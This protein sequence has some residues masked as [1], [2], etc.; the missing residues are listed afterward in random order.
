MQTKEIKKIMRQLRTYKLRVQDVPE[1][2][3]DNMDI[4][5]AERRYGLRKSGNRG[6]DAINQE[7]FVEEEIFYKNFTGDMSGFS[8]KKVFDEFEAYYNFLKGDIYVNSCYCYYD[9]SKDEEFIKKNKIDVEKLQERKA[10]ITQTIDDITVDISEEELEAY[11]EAEKTKEL[12]K[13]WIVRFDSCKSY[14]ELSKTVQDYR[15]SELADTVDV[16]FFFFNYIYKDITDK[17]RFNIIMEY[18]SAGDYPDYKIIYEICHIYDPDEILSNYHYTSGTKNKIYTRKKRLK[19]YIDKVKNKEIVFS[20]YRYFDKH[21]H[22]Y[23]EELRGYVNHIN[24]VIPPIVTIYRYFE[25]FDEFV[26]HINGNLKSCDLS[27]AIK[28]NVDFSKYETDE[29]TKLPIRKKDKLVCTVEKGFRRNGRYGNSFYVKQQWRNSIGCFITKNEFITNY[30]FDFVYFLKGD[31]SNADLL[32]CDGLSNITD[33]VGIDFSSAKLTSRLCEIFG[34]QYDIFK[35]N[36]KVIDS[37]E[38]TEK[39]EKETSLI[40]NSYEKETSFILNSPRDSFFEDTRMYEQSLKSQRISYISDLHLMHRIDNAK[41]KS[42]NDIIYVIQN[43]INAIVSETSGLLLI[44]GDIASDFKVFKLFIS[45][46][47]KSFKNVVFILGNHELW[48]FPGK[49]FE[50]ITEIYRKLIEEN[51]MYFIQN[52]LLYKD[53]SNR[54][55]KISYE[56]LIKKDK[57]QIRNQLRCARLVILGGLGFSGY[58]MEFNAD[59]GIYRNILNRENE[60]MET[61]KF[62]K[63]YLSM[64]ESIYDKNVIIFTHTPIEDWCKKPEY[65]ENFVYVSGHTHRNYFYDDGVYKVYSDNQIGYHN[66]NPHL[67][68]FLMDN[69]YDFFSDFE[70]GIHEITVAQYKEFY[71]GKNIPMDLTRELFVLY[72]LKKNGYYCF[73]HESEMS[74]FT[75]LNGAERRKLEKKGLQYYYDHMDNVIE[76]IKNPLDKYMSVQQKVSNEIQKIGGSGRIHGCIVDVDFYN[77]IYINPTDM[78][79]TGYWALDMINKKVYPDI[80]SLLKSECPMLYEKYVKFIEENSSSALVSKIDSE[81]DVS[82]LPQE[83]LSTDIYKVSRQIKKMQKLTSNILSFWD[84]GLIETNKLLEGE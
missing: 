17:N 32:F 82:L 75:I 81:S 45:L 53:S 8:A 16:V 11:E 6:F 62:E 50:E 41:C 66:E 2:F 39:N 84:E 9:F 71:R 25:T 36:R 37:F 76:C 26:D 38:Q 7:F 30:F 56:E 59:N 28:I 29:E 77:H 15:E 48:N 20:V 18:I 27:A 54:I 47:K 13:E 78:K 80:P 70:D 42:E 12:C 58:N 55:N 83:Y 23:C 60:V 52:D 33:S 57:K 43:I 64:L 61:I 65:Q 69:E 19:G 68:E 34:V 5:K 46:L 67:K 24:Q 10:F 14:E 63:L 79:I 3:R 31:L 73:I 4:I 21:T 22:F 51:G 72:M 49:T 74:S 44:G 40:L 35:L 1:E